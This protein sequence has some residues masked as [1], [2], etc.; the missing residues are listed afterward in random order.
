MFAM[1]YSQAIEYLNSYINYEKNLHE[2][3]PTFFRLER[4]QR[5]LQAIGE[6]Q[7]KLK[8]VHVAGTK[9]KGS[10]CALVANILKHQGY[11]V[12]L[13]TSPHINSVRERI[14][15][16]EKGKIGGGS[17]DIFP[18]EIPEADMANVIDAL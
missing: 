14:R 8:F 2:I 18:D 12:G 17:D 7:K 11:R 16:L 9:G 15:V 10:T 4:V 13:F 5:L 1:N 3:S 6:P